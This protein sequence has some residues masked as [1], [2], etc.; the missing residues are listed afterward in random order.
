MGDSQDDLKTGLH[1]FTV[2]DALEEYHQANLELACNYSLLYDTDH[3]IVYSDL[4]AL[5]AK[6]EHSILLNYFELGN[7]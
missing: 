4:Q 3:G 6:E 1:P 2:A 7:H 5:K